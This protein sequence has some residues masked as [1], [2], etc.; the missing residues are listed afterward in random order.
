MEEEDD[1]KSKAA[2]R[3]KKKTRRKYP[4]HGSSLR[5]VY[6]NVVLKRSSREKK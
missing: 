4:V 3:E 6:P 2:R 1:L 5:V